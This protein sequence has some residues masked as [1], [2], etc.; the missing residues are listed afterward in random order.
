MIT[1]LTSGLWHGANWTFVFWG[2]MHGIAQVFENIIGLGKDKNQ[3]RPVIARLV[4]WF[5]VFVFCN[6]AW[7]F[8][9]AETIADAIFVIRN[10]FG[11]FS[12]ID[13]Y[14]YTN[15]GLSKKVLLFII[16]NIMIVT[17]FD[18]FSIKKDVVQMAVSKNRLLVVG[19][20]YAILVIIIIAVLFGAGANQ[21]VYF[22]F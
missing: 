1:F 21:F 13:K 11:Y 7:V 17:F 3:K 18:Y 12:H 6:L 2:G 22:Q 8:F 16:F 9:R 4:S 10:A 5:A 20:E 15:I 19:I 14:L